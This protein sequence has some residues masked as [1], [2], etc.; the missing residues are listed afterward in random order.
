MP[1]AT[2]LLQQ[3]LAQL[4]ARGVTHVP[5]SATAREQLTGTRGVH[6]AA[7][8]RPAPASAAAMDKA[9][10]L[11]DLA[12]EAAGNPSFRALGSLRD[13]MVF[14]T[15]SPDAELMF[16]GEAPG[17]EEERKGEPF[18]GPAGEMLTNIIRAMGFRR[19][20]V[21]ISNICKFRPLV[22][23]GK[24]QGERNRPPASEEMHA[25]LPFITAEI[26]I[27]QPR[28]IVALGATASNGLGIEGKVGSLRGH[29]HEFRGIPVMV[30]YHPSYLLRREKETGGG[31][32]EKRLVWEDLLQVLERLGRTV[33]PKQR[34][35]FTEAK[36]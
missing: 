19:G 33:T 1:E 17:A 4:A 12:A 22:D 36:S 3:H 26:E 28:V 13:T 24:P 23:D 34:A 16:V 9:G 14:A 6:S 15:G 20:E 2:A 10:R 11:T 21:Y 25:C 5:L 35:Y 8:A 18:V 31:I 29:F 7:P 32:R 27:V 30:T